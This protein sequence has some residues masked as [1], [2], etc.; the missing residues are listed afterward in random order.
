MGEWSI[1]S[2]VNS[3]RALQQL[4]KIKVRPDGAQTVLNIIKEKKKKK[5][6]KDD[7]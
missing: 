1:Y 5:K 2:K 3:I 4:I 7:F 6:K